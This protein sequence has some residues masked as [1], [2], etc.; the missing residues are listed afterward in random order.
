MENRNAGI[1]CRCG[2][3]FARQKLNNMAIGEGGKERA[4]GRGGARG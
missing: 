1:N 4:I 2:E 3:I